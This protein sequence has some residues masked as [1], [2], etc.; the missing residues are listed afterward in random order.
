MTT[1][2]RP[3]GRMGIVVGGG[4]AP[5]INSVIAAAATEGLRR[6]L[7][8]VGIYDGFKWLAAGSGEHTC[9][10][11]DSIAEQCRLRGGSILRTSREKPADDPDKMA[12]VVAT[13]QALDI[14]YLVTIGGDDT[15]YTASMTSR[16]SDGRIQVAHVP[17]TIDNDLPLP[18]Q[19]P[20]FGYNTARAVGANLIGNLMEDAHTTAR[21]YVVTAM[22][23]SAGH[24]ALGM[25]SSGGATAAVIPEEFQG[26]ASLDLTL[27]VIE[28]SMH[29]S[30]ILGRDFGV[31]VIAEG[32]GELIVAD[33]QGRPY[34]SITHDKSGNLRLAE[35]P[36][37][38]ILKDELKKR[39]KERGRKRTIVDVVIGYELRCAPPAPFDA[40]YCR[41]LGWGAVQYVLGADPSWER[42]GALIALKAGRIE[43]IPFGA[44]LDPVTGKTAIRRVDVQADTYKAARAAMVRLS[45]EDLE[46]GDTLG[47]LADVAGLSPAEYRAAYADAAAI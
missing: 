31:V 20:T 9:T 22:G 32:V 47:R 43:P 13:L 40:D 5:G 27:K 30:A 42:G 16:T 18:D 4:P 1:S 6:G 23:R 15:A 14:A 39:L 38:L 2:S 21:W 7:E 10:I 24:L 44:I 34:V 8:V 41:Q 29:R 26:S 19:A 28:G 11:T 25:A 3:R 46:N 33:L 36:L 12:R 37:A 35:V 45:T 17:K